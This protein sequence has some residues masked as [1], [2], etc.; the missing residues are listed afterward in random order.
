MLLRNAG[1]QP[2]TRAQQRPIRP[3]PHRDKPSISHIKDFVL[4]AGSYVITFNV[5]GSVHRKYIPFNI[6]PRCNFTQFIYFSKTALHISGGISTHHQEHIKLYLQYLV[7]AKPLLL[8]PLL[9]ISWSWFECDEGIL[10][11]SFGSVADVS[12]K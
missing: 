4:T 5:Q 2:N 1:N 8:L 12:Q 7:L 9:W 10:L 11:I 6:F 3:H